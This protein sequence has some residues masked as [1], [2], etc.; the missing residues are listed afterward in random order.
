MLKY[1]EIKKGILLL[2]DVI[3]FDYYKELLIYNFSREEYV[4]GFSV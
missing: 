2:V 4:W 3:D 1:K